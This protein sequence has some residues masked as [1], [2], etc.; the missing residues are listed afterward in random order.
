MIVAFDLETHLIAPGMKAP[1]AV[2]M[3]SSARPK[4]L[5]N[6]EIT[7]AINTF[8]F[9]LRL[10]EGW[11]DSGFTLVGHN[12]TYD[13]GV[14]V[15]ER[16]ALLPKV[17]QAF[18]DGRIKCTKI[19]EQLIRI[20]KGELKYEIDEDGEVVKT[21]L[22]LSALCQQYLGEHLEKEN[23]PRL[24]Y[25]ELDGKPLDEW[26]SASVEYAMRDAYVT[27]RIYEAQ[28]LE[29]NRLGL[30]NELEQNQ[31]A[32][33]LHLMG[34]WGVRTD[35][36]AVK[37]FAIYIEARANKAREYLKGVG[38]FRVSGSKK[39]PKNTQD[40]KATRERVEAWFKVNN[41]SVPLTKTGQT[42]TSKKTLKST[43]DKDL[44][45]LADGK[46]DMKLL[47]TYVPILWRGTELPLCAD[48]NVL[49][50]TGRTSCSAG[51]K[52]K[53]EPSLGANMQNPPRRSRYRQCFIPRP[54]HVWCGADYDT[55]EFRALGQDCLELFGFSEIARAFQN[56]ED[57]HLN[58]AA[59]LLGISP[60]EARARYK[61]G[62]TEISDHR[63]LM[64]IANYGFA[65]ALG[66]PTFVNYARGFDVEITLEE[67]QRLRKAFLNTWIEMQDYFKFVNR[68]TSS[69]TGT[70]V[71]P[72]SG[73]ICGQRRYSQYANARFQG[74]VA[75]GAKAALVDVTRECYT[76]RNSPLWGA[77]PVLFLHDEL[78]LEIPEAQAS[79]AAARQT[80]LMIAAMRRYIPDVPVTCE[81]ALMRRWYK[82]AKPLYV[83]GKLVPVKPIYDGAKTTWV[84]DHG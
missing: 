1:K 17:F 8:P 36:V 15:A 5:K 50:D 30:T 21:N 63:Q 72:I 24:K 67:S 14:L 57:P 18:D 77:R 48:Y 39:N 23:T 6:P 79:A 22:S 34:L 4:Q 35:P 80:E 59:M 45:I 75:D 68:E 51:R 61:A 46:E 69:G 56:G 53:G 70:L 33:A 78:I 60:S 47:D 76:D 37:E 58:L 83:D 13:I 11:L 41:Q 32:W 40:M 3:T 65:G 28:Q 29:W 42:S 54:E 43:N 38:L 84:Q 31:A 66:A 49:V 71:H 73:R 44:R 19:K 7:T 12:V 62:D 55:V 82:G 52:R 26:P 10:F 25:H 64:K 9:S 81:P 74:R 2:C 20:A 16:P 27:Y